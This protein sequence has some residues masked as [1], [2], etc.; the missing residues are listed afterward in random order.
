MGALHFGNGTH[1]RLS[2][3]ATASTQGSPIWQVMDPATKEGEGMDPATT[4]AD[5]ATNGGEGTVLAT[6][7]ADPATNS[8][9]GAD[10]CLPPT[11]SQADLVTLGL[12][13]RVEQ[14]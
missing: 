14:I 5:P 12:L 13:L 3:L 6:T 10:P 9:G 11:T 1:T 4:D 8:G 7:K 2:T